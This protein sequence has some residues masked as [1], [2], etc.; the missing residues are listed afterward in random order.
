MTSA[1]HAF[2]NPAYIRIRPFYQY[3]DAV[4]GGYPPYFGLCH[5]IC[6]AFPTAPAGT[7]HPPAPG[8]GKADRLGQRVP[9]LLPR[10]PPT[11]NT[12]RASNVA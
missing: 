5:D 8:M 11:E 3:P 7:P 9:L 12:L 4:Y 1:P 10:F 6:T 2:T